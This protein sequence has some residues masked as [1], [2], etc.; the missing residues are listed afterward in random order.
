MFGEVRIEDMPL[1][2][3]C[4]STNLSRGELYVHRQGKLW[5]AVRASGSIP[6]LLPP[7]FTDDGSM[8]VDGSLID[9]VPVKT[10]RE[11][12]AGPNVVL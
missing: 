4:V 10:M 2:F 12:K 8:L 3:F 6:G 9:N 5:E 11:L 7:M 1:P